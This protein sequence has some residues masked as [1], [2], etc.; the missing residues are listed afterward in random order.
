MI[1]FLTIIGAR[2]QIIKAAAL[3]RSIKNSFSDKITEVLL[4]TGQHY[5]QDMS[6][7]FFGELNIPSPDYNLNIGADAAVNQIARMIT[8]IFEVIDIEKPDH[9]IVYGDTNSTLA[10]AIAAN[11]CKIPLV[12]IEAGLRS[13]NRSMP[14]ENNRIIADHFSTFLFCP[15][16]TA[17]INLKNEGF[18]IDNNSAASLDEPVIVNNGDVMY[19][20]S[21]FFGELSESKSE[22][23]EDNSLKEDQFILVTVHRPSNTDNIQNLTSIFEACCDLADKKEKIFL[24]LHPRTRNAMLSL[25]A[26]LIE[27]ISSNKNIIIHAPVSF[28]EITLLEKKCKLVITDSGGIQKEAYFFKKPCIVLRDETEWVELLDTGN[29]VLSGPNGQKIFEAF[30]SIIGQKK[31]F[32]K[33]FGS[34]KASE[35]ICSRILKEH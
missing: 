21:L 19:D 8:G 7:V 26:D 15:T 13:F 9:L 10:G 29:S 20:N 16:E 6:E 14:E 12:H 18:E 1:K 31:S 24:P 23:L 17:M 33:I 2:P 34:G 28:L 35:L 3:S 11:K 25:S 30:D 5:D 4:H 32:P 27:R 22:I